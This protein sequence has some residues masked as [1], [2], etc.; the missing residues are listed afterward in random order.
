M[1][2]G[3]R[4]NL[5]CFELVSTLRSYAAAAAARGG[6]Q[7]GLRTVGCWRPMNECKTEIIKNI[8]WIRVY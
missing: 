8:L 2:S 4:L 6:E 7:A 1:G 3:S 5:S